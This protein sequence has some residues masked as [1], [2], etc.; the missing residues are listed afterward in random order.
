M[1]DLAG[2]GVDAA[3]GSSFRH[4]NE[5]SGVAPSEGAQLVIYAP[6]LRLLMAFL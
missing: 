2:D 3:A 1:Q 4:F 6:Q 5:V